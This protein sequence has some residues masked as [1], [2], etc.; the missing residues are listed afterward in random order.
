MYSPVPSSNLGTRKGLVVN[1]MLL[2]PG[3]DKDTNTHTHTHTLTHT[4]IHTHNSSRN[5]LFSFQKQHTHLR[6]GSIW[7]TFV[8]Y[9][10][11]RIEWFR[12]N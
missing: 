1:A 8:T 2:T 6:A 10:S 11:N 3:K 7:N 12:L 9:L 4:H 5:L